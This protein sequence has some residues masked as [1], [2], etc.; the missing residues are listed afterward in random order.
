MLGLAMT[1]VTELIFDTVAGREARGSPGRSP[2]RLQGLAGAAVCDAS[3]SSGCRPDL[4]RTRRAARPVAALPPRR[5]T[6]AGPDHR[7]GPGRHRCI[8]HRQTEPRPRRSHP[9]PVHTDGRGHVLR[10]DYRLA[11]ANPAG[12]G[13]SALT[14]Q[15]PPNQRNWSWARS[16]AASR[17]GSHTHRNLS[18]G[19]PSG[20]HR[21]S[22]A[23]T[24]ASPSTTAWSGAT[25][26]RMIGGHGQSLDRLLTR[27][28]DGD[29]HRDLG[30]IPDAAPS[31]LRRTRP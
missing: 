28:R 31:S 17:S 14:A 26:I 29:G 11:A 9:G 21:R 25:L 2:L 27:H 8:P 24:D 18:D 6:V 7:P 13:R 30:H 19:P 12:V 1:G 22:P 20:R 16:T 10:T 23:G 15:P 5:G 3:G 4:S